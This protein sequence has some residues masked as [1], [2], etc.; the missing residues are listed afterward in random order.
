MALPPTDSQANAQSMASIEAFI[1]RANA[2]FIAST[3]ILINNATQLG[4]FRVE[5]F[6]TPFLDVTTVTAY[7]EEFGYTV[8]FPIIPPG[9]YNPCFVAGFP[10][11]LPPG[12][13]TWNCHC[14]SD[15]GPLRI[16]ISWPSP[17]VLESFMLT[18]SGDFI[19]LEN[20]LGQLI[21]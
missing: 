2:A 10:E 14:C 3:T 11:V 6:I 12:Y 16:K 13:R 20:G 7:F 17:P 8:E 5:P 19:E 15:C 9:P 18:E 1:A 21:F 4:F